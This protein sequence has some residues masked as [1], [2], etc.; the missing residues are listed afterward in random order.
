MNHTTLKSLAALGA[1]S[2]AAAC[3]PN[4]EPEQTAKADEVAPK[5][6]APAATT[7]PEAPAKPAP[8]EEAAEATPEPAEVTTPDLHVSTLAELADLLGL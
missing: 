2:L 6:A 3:A 4:N 8:A 5:S 7:T 1:L